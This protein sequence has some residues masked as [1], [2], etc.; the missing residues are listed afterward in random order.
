MDRLIRNLLQIRSKY[1]RE[2]YLN[3]PMNISYRRRESAPYSETTSSGFTT[4]PLL[5]LILWARATKRIFGLSF[6]TK[7][8]PDFKTYVRSMILSKGWRERERDARKQLYPVKGC[9]KMEKNLCKHPGHTFSSGILSWS[10]SPNLSAE[11]ADIKF[12][13]ESR[14]AMYWTWNLNH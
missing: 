13:S 9:I 11:S 1:S 12:P 10:T 6:R 14:K 4:F 7:E 3:G 8:S 2:A 5:L